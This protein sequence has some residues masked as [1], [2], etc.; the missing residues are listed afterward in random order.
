MK[1]ILTYVGRRRTDEKTWPYLHTHARAS[2]TAPR[3]LRPHFHASSPTPHISSTSSCLDPRRFKPLHRRA[4]PHPPQSGDAKIQSGSGAGTSAAAGS[5]AVAQG[6]WASGFSS[7][8]SSGAGTSTL[9]RWHG[10]IG[11]GAGTLASERRLRWHPEQRRPGV[12]L[13]TSVG[14]RWL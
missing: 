13:M 2:I 9:G 7:I 3:S 8:R 1:N 4:P 12:G 11:I 14:R 10:D 6:R 5:R